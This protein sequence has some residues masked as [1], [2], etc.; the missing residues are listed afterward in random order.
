[1]ARG[2]SVAAVLAALACIAAPVKAE[3]PAKSTSAVAA[4]SQK[5]VADIQGFRSAKFGIDEGMVRKAIATDFGIKDDKVQR[6]EHPTE[7]TTILAVSVQ[8]LLPDSG[9]AIVTYVLGYRSKKLVQVNV[10]WPK[11]EDT[12]LG[13][14]AIIL[15]NYFA[16]MQ[17]PPD[18]AVADAQLPD[19]GILAFRG[20]DQ[21]GH[22]VAVLFHST[23]KPKKDDK[24][25]QPKDEAALHLSYV[26]S[27]N[28]P[29]VFTLE[30]GKF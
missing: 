4:E 7:K 16:A 14:A 11:G 22:M 8:N 25:P 2:F 13:N 27:P 17:F 9:N 15:R 21:H 18:S 29:D 20:S 3:T 10:I 23:P 24:G 28:K 26:E 30:P 5:P 1:M 12:A 6:E 19:G